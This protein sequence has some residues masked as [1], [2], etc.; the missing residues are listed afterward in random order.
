MEVPEYKLNKST[1]RATIIIKANFR[2]LDGSTLVSG[3]V[4]L[5]K[6]IKALETKHILFQGSTYQLESH[7]MEFTKLGEDYEPYD[8]SFIV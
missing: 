7:W 4:P 2:S 5:S 6:M 1:K 3:K 8:D